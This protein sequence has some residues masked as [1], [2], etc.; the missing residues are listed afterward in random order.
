MATQPL[1]TSQVILGWSWILRDWDRSPWDWDSLTFRNF[2]STNLSQMHQNDLMRRRKYAQD[3]II[4]LCWVS[5]LLIYLIPILVQNV[6]RDKYTTMKQKYKH[7]V[8]I[9]FKSR[10]SP[11]DADSNIL[12]VKLVVL[13]FWRVFTIMC[14]SF[15]RDSAQLGVPKAWRFLLAV[16]HLCKEG[17]VSQIHVCGAYLQDDFKSHCHIESFRKKSRCGLSWCNF[18]CGAACL[19][20]LHSLQDSI[21]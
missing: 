18:K 3:P 20:I 21:L 14:N 17:S 13:G 1:C 15:T 9:L 7:W 11:E 10:F 19:S 4:P 2:Q 5:L 12:P 6:F 16:M 8:C